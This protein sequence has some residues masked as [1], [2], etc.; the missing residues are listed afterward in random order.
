MPKERQFNFIP[1]PARKKLKPQRE[2]CVSIY[3]SG[4]MSI[5]KDSVLALGE[6]FGSKFFKFY[7]DEDKRTVAW[8][9]SSSDKDMSGNDIRF[10]GVTKTGGSTESLRVSIRNFVTFLPDI[11]LPLL[12]LKIEKYKDT[13]KYLGIGELYYVT[14]PRTKL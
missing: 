9:M 6:S 1:L 2:P 12:K 8:K 5:P 14:I 10:I 7:Y 3:K 4:M 11:Q 13:D